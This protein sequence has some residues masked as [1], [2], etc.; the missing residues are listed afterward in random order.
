MKSTCESTCSRVGRSG[1]GAFASPSQVAYA[2]EIWKK[3]VLGI[4]LGTFRTL[5][6]S[7]TPGP[8]K[9][10]CCHVLFKAFVQVLI[11]AKVLEIYHFQMPLEALPTGRS[12]WRTTHLKARFQRFLPIKVSTS[13]DFNHVL[14][15]K[16]LFNNFQWNKFTVFNSAQKERPLDYQDWLFVNVG[17]TL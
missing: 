12:G 3:S 8:R 6:R 4:E 1:M 17:R 5:A 16:H 11:C 14:Y 15:Q 13:Y 2:C 9:Q 10:V 7:L